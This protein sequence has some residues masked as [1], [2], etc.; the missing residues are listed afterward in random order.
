[1]LREVEDL[2]HNLSI[3]LS[4]GASFEAAFQEVAQLHRGRV[5]KLLIK[6][7]R[8][9]TTGH[10]AEEALRR[11]LLGVRAREASRLLLLV[12]RLSSY[13]SQRAGFMLMS[14]VELLERNRALK[15]RLAASV[16]R[17]GFK[18]N[19]LS[20]LYPMV[21]AALYLLLR[22]ASWLTSSLDAMDLL[23]LNFTLASLS[24]VAPFYASL[25]TTGRGS[26]VR[27]I[28]SLSIYASLQIVFMSLLSLSSS[29]GF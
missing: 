25:I 3:R 5:R 10:T 6:A 7:S 15:E 20:T 23:A 14:V 11:F 12:P 21:L 24:A 29:A 22:V 2:L 4:Q 16:R 8:E 26:V 9:L 19:V 18:V 27:S 13:S 17:E 28:T 1:V